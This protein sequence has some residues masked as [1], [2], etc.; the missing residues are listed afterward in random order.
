[1]NSVSIL[2]STYKIINQ[3]FKLEQGSRVPGLTHESGFGE[4]PLFEALALARTAFLN[5]P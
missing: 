3:S 5:V 4:V 2:Q 1:M